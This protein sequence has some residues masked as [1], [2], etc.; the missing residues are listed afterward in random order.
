MKEITEGDTRK[1]E[2]DIELQCTLI[3]R[4]IEHIQNNSNVTIKNYNLYKYLNLMIRNVLLS[5]L[6]AYDSIE[7]IQKLDDKYSK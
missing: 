4:Y 6:D 5:S 2:R 1:L 7:E 3:L